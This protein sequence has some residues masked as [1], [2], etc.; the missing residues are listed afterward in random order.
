M[1]DAL[2][3]DLRAAARSLRRRPGFA[4]A[5]ILT[6]ALAS[7]VATSLF[8]IVNELVLRPVPGV[9]TDG[10]VKV[11]VTRDGSIDGLSGH[12]HPTFQDYVERSRSFTGLGALA[13]GGFA[14][15]LDGDPTLVLG[16]F[17]SSGFFETI[18]T[19]P[20]LGRLIGPADATGPS[21]AVAVISH[22]YWVDRFGAA[23]GVLG[24]ILRINGHAV[25]VVGVAEP[26]FRGPFI[27]FPSDVFVP[28]PLAERL[29]PRLDLTDRRSDALEIY[30]H[31][32]PGVSIAAAQADLEPITADLGRE[33]P[34]VFRRR[35]VRVLAWHGLDADP[36]GPALG[37][38]GVL[39][40]IAGLVVIIACVNVA[41][42]LLHRGQLRRG[43]MAVRQALGAG[44][45]V[46]TRELAI[47]TLLLFAAAQVAGVLLASSG[48]RWL[49]AFLPEFAIPIRLDLAVDW[50]VW[51]LA[52]AVTFG[53]A[54]V[55]GILPAAAATRIDPSVALKPGVVGSPR[56]FRMRRALD[57]AQVAVALVLLATAGLFARTVSRAATL[58][59]GFDTTAAGLATADV[60]VVS[61]DES[62]GR[63]YFDAWLARVRRQPGIESAA[64]ASSVPLALGRVT[65][66]LT[67]DGRDPL[68][69]DVAASRSIVTNDYF[70]S[71][72]IPILA[73]R[74]LAAADSARSEPV[75]VVSRTAARRLFGTTDPIGRVLIDA[76]AQT[77][78]RIVGVAGDVA[79]QRPGEVDTA[80]FYV[81]FAQQYTPRLSLV[82]RSADPNLL[83]VLRREA[84]GVNPDVPILTAETLG[85]RRAT[86]LFPQRMAA[87]LAAALGVLGLG[88]AVVGLYGVVAV[89]ATARDRELAVRL[90]FGATRANIRRLMIGGGLRPVV[91]GLIVGIP[92]AGLL[93][94]TMRAF[95]PGVSVWDPLVLGA[96]AAVLA[97]TSTVAA[98]LPAW[99]ASQLDP[100][101]LLRRE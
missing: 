6:M 60:S 1:A 46:L 20:F 25:T 12:A 79:L 61:P 28:L 95:L 32:R 65:T 7:G 98:G 4:A 8:T 39:A 87:S 22:A 70:R 2:A 34:D 63:A 45:G 66:P 71:M 15:S 96:G 40:T 56:Q 73:G 72:G 82:A 90:A 86:V 101:R 33:F 77:R 37:F 13:G 81:P 50:R 16:A 27:G 41:G 84:R 14:V 52:A 67:V 51:L 21:P 100:M 64:L 88:L 94:G 43:E 11:Y 59:T 5:V 78:R 19:T 75:A 83:D 92:A 9:R 35:G 80:V 3:R 47:E 30:G 42:L 31:L 76:D 10:L 62:A 49:H 91:F 18:G 36:A 69:G 85:Q 68:A 93:A 97:L 29:S 55:F 38:V 44:R 26:G 74:T 24:R 89:E 17:V 23:P 57:A 58:P 48:T 54:L 53:T 99:R